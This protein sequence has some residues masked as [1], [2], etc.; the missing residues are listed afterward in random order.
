LLKVERCGSL[1][2]EQRRQVL[3]NQI[4]FRMSILGVAIIIIFF[5]AVGLLWNSILVTI[6]MGIACSLIAWD[7]VA[8]Y[9]LIV[10]TQTLFQTERN[11]FWIKAR[12]FMEN[13][14]EK[15]NT[16][17]GTSDVD[18]FI[19]LLNKTRE[20]NESLWRYIYTEIEE[21]YGYINSLPVEQKIFVL[22]TDYV[23]FQNY[24]ARCSWLLL[25]HIE[26]DECNCEMLYKKFIN[27]EE[28]ANP[29]T[30][31]ALLDFFNGL[32]KQTVDFR[33]L[34]DTELNEEP[35]YVP[36]T[37]LQERKGSTLCFHSVTDMN[38]GIKKKK[39]ISFMPYMKL[40]NI[41]S[42]NYEWYILIADLLKIKPK[43]F[44]EILK[45]TFFWIQS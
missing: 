40:E 30:I 42:N 6:T 21:L 38:L 18:K 11:A 14:T 19:E 9:D 3:I 22:S 31:K 15:I 1:D 33:K 28:I 27:V 13:I 29:Q 2:S 43:L 41:F 17:T 8:I 25:G 5:Y 32:N 36:D 37:I 7:V 34:K 26:S 39:I 24:I 12:D 45:K 4:L 10:E 44:V 35:F 20:E 23:L 16:V